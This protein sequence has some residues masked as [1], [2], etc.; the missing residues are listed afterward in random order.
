VKEE[1]KEYFQNLDAL[2]FIAAFA[3]LLSHA[4]SYLKIPDSGY[5]KFLNIALTFDSYGG[6]AAVSFFFVLSGFLITYLMFVERDKTG[7]FDLKYFYVRRIL[8]IWP[9]YF[10]TLV[11]GFIIYPALT[12]NAH[13]VEHASWKMY[14]LFLANFDNMYQGWPANGILGVQWSLAVEEQFYLVWPLIFLFSR[15]RKVFGLLTFCFILVA[16]CLRCAGLPKYHPL[17]ALGDLSTGAFMAYLAI[18][19]SEIV[20]NFFSR[21]SKVTTLLVYMAGVAMILFNFQLN[22]HFS[23]FHFFDRPLNALFFSFVILDQNYSPNSFFKF[24]SIKTLSSLG[25]ISYGIYSLHMVAIYIV[26]FISTQILLEPIAG[27]MLVIIISILLSYV[28]YYFFERYFLKL[29]DRFVRR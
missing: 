22:K 24:G 3:V 8:R 9:L 10:L 26:I 25:K 19:Q 1:Q 29:K 18:Y 5:Y 28:S 16:F 7:S 23:W 13:Y 17:V 15:N 12:N 11:I 20:C 21:R 27:I 14:S 4:P 6:D 2:R